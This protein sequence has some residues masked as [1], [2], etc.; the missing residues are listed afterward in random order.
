MFLR[1]GRWRLDC[2]SALSLFPLP[3]CVSGT[4]AAEESI[5]MVLGSLATANPVGARSAWR[6]A[7]PP[8]ILPKPPSFLSVRNLFDR[9]STLTERPRKSNE[10]G[11]FTFPESDRKQHLSAFCIFVHSP[12]SILRVATVSVKGVRG[13]TGGADLACFWG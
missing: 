1:R 4:R 3:L 7:S 11:F 9:P 6:Q 10:R 12:K 5:L 2:S 13:G 8:P